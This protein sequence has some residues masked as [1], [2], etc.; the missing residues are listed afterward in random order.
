[1]QF[2][3]ISNGSLQPKHESDKVWNCCQMG[4]RNVG[5]VVGPKTAY[6]IV[7]DC[8]ESKFLSQLI[9][10]ILSLVFYHSILFFKNFLWVS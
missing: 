4:S 9:L 7:R 3:F 8:F 1:M 5:K 10:S 6:G 2:D